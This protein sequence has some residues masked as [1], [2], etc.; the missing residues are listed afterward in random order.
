MSNDV[1][2]APLDPQN[3]AHCEAV[4]VLLSDYFDEIF[5]EKPAE[6]IPKHVIPRLVH[7]IGEETAKYKQ[8][9]YL[10][11]VGDEYIG[12]ANFQIDTPES[13]LCKRR[14]W[15]FIREFYIAPGFRRMG[16]AGQLCAF[17]EGVLAKNAA[18]DIYLTARKPARPFW[19]AM[20]YICT[21][22]T[23]PQNGNMIYEKHV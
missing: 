12:F 8:W 14:G 10:C 11:R 9:M 16:Y 5:A 18:G 4:I 22:R 19:Q 13:P 1:E 2:F 23:D 20:G 15:G 6:S 21:G 7:T 17:A 3:P